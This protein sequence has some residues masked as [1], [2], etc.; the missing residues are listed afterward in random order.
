MNKM[1][2]MYKN[3][4][5]LPILA[6]KSIKPANKLNPVMYAKYLVNSF[7]LNHI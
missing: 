5:T 4:I 7:I 6:S 2:K 1:G 3:T